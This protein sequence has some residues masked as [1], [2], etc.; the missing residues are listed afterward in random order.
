MVPPGPRLLATLFHLPFAGACL[1]GCLLF[2]VAVPAASGYNALYAFGDSLTDTGNNPASPATSYYNGRYSNGPLWVEYMSTN[3]GF[4]FV[5]SNNYA[6][7][8]SE[9]ADALLAVQNLPPP[10]NAATTLFAVW[11]GGNDFLDNAS[12]T[13]QQNDPLWAGVISNAVYNLTNAVAVLYADGAR[14]IIVP[15]LP[16]L[17][18]LPVASAF[19]SAYR[20]YM[21][22]KIGLYNTN[23]LQALNQV[24][25][26]RPNL[27]LLCPNIFTNFNNI[28]A[29]PAAYGF[30]KSTA[31]A[32]EDSSLSDKSFNG[33]GSDYV[34]WDVIH[35]TTKAHALIANW[36]FSTL[37]STAPI[38]LSIQKSAG[39]I[40]LRWTNPSFVLQSAA[41]VSGPFA[42]VPGA[43]S[44]F[45]NNSSPSQLFFRLQTP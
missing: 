3:L 40:V 13:S 42:A 21:S 33:P 18:K 5:Q 14:T 20:T 38:P 37:P 6:Y 36:I 26:G 45:T 10:V 24:R 8:G 34:F 25:S 11:S 16:D 1:L 44:P 22:G 35:P 23:L 32:L 4:A 2:L 31:G 41:N 19:T 30:T 12:L 9:T 29:N 27:D 17:S 28:L 39:R 7:S 43:S 15:N